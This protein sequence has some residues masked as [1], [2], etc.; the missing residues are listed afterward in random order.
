HPRSQLTSLPICER[1]SR[2]PPRQSLRT[3]AV[4][5]QTRSMTGGSPALTAEREISRPGLDRSGHCCAAL[6]VT[7]Q[8]PPARTP[9]TLAPSQRPPGAAPCDPL[10][11]CS[12]LCHLPSTL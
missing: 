11:P 12:R 4:P 1:L 7:T 5:F 8:L 9:V 10:L 2:L 3:L 6:I